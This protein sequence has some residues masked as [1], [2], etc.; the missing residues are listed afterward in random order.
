MRTPL[1]REAQPPFLLPHAAMELRRCGRI[2][3]SLSPDMPQQAEGMPFDA[4]GGRVFETCAF[5]LPDAWRPGEVAPAIKLDDER[6][7]C[8][9]SR[10]PNGRYGFGVPDGGRFVSWAC[11][12]PIG[13]VWNVTV[14]TAPEARGQGYAAACVRALS[15]DMLGR[16]VTPLYLCDAGN[17]ASRGVALR[18]GY[19]PY[20]SWLRL[21]R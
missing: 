15:A 16:G 21:V 3:R 9:A 2:Y 18:A 7:I 19:V 5:V 14:E 20:G 12:S 17:A 8:G 13:Q 11:A 1:R 6:E 4:L 10:L